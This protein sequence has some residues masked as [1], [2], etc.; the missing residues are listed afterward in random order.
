MGMAAV[1]AVPASMMVV[2]VVMAIVVVVAVVVPLLF[3]NSGSLL[4]A[5]VFKERRGR[6][7]W[8][9]FLADLFVLCV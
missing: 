8:L 3:L 6:V 5:F 9:L 1:M 4:P 7:A 2:V